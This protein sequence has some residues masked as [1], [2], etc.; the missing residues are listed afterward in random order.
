MARRA[1]YRERMT[2]RS[3]AAIVLLLISAG[4]GAA[5][6]PTD[7]LRALFDRANRVLVAPYPD[8]GVEERLTAVRGLVGE[9]FDFEGAAALALGRHWNTLP[10]PERAAF[11]QLYAD[12][13][14]RAYLAWVGS[15]A[16]IGEGGVSI[17]WL[18]E[19][20]D[21]DTAR[22]TSE[23]LTRA[24]VERPIEYHMVRRA[25]HWLVRDVVVDGVSLAANY[26]VQFDRVLQLGSYEELLARLRDKAGP[27]AR[28]QASAASA[29]AIRATV[30]A[31]PP[32]VTP[33]AAATPTAGIVIAELRDAPAA[34]ASDVTPGPL[35]RSAAAPT[36]DTA[37]LAPARAP[38][39]LVAPPAAAVGAA[40]RTPRQFWVQVGAFRSTD[41]A[42][43]LV[44]RLRRHAVTVVTGGDRITPMLRVLVGPFRERGAAVAAARSLQ[45]GGIAAFIADSAE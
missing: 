35:A 6:E 10:P 23:L 26:H 42:T 5:G 9:V 33:A 29:S 3:L 43:R 1:G 44:E 38:A 36:I 7:R 40:P 30:A 39:P 12:V 34:V 20:V 13:I 18:D 37:A 28:E 19:S 41:A 8:A 11:T 16:R 32:V 17:R 24:G 14:E 2:R 4:P 45:A 27:M 25:Q 22:V 21:G 31:P 15:R